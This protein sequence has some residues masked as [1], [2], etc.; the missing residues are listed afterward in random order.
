MLQWNDGACHSSKLEQIWL[1]TN[2]SYLRFDLI[3]IIQINKRRRKRKNTI[4]KVDR[5]FTF[6][7]GRRPMIWPLFC[8]PMTSLGYIMIMMLQCSYSIVFIF[9]PYIHQLPIRI[10][11]IRR[12]M[13]LN[14]TYVP[15]IF[16]IFINVRSIHF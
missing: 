7:L 10:N 9:K 4:R 15:R 3:R 13:N 6:P 12:G 8:P 1:T 2:K 14:I 11:K 16:L 5:L